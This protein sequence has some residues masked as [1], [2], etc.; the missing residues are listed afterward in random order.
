[1]DADRTAPTQVNIWWVVYVKLGQL[2][3]HSF[4]HLLFVY[5]E[6][7]FHFFQRMPGNKDRKEWPILY[8]RAKNGAVRQWQVRVERQEEGRVYIVKVYGQQDGKL[9][10]TRKEV[11][12]AKSQPTIWDQACRDAAKMHQDEIEKK[13]YSETVPTAQKR[14][15]GSEKASNNNKKVKQSV[16]FYPML[17]HKWPD[18]KHHMPF[19]CT[20]QPKLDGVRAWY[21]GGVFRSR[22]GKVFPQFKYLESALQECNLGR[23]I[24][25]D[26]ELY[27]HAI[28][29][30]TL[31][32]ICNRKGA[33]LTEVGDY[34]IG[35]YIFDAYFLAAPNRGFGARY[36]CLTKLLANAPEVVHIVG[37][38]TLQSESDVQLH[39]DFWT[40]KGYEGLMLRD[41]E[42]PYLVKHRSMKLLKYKVFHDAEFKIVGAQEGE[43]KEEG[44]LVWT[45]ETKDGEAFQC[46]PRGSH[47]ERQRLWQAFGKSP[48][49]YVGQTLTVR[50]QETYANGKPRFPVGI[51][52]RYQ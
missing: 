41:P 48:N 9:I 10:Q 4:R 20:G 26:G 52:I 18:K 12:R 38:V 21:Q 2:R 16:A 23:N 5:T 15:K 45:L 30:R 36:E 19:P 25:L 47:E 43:G 28:P 17:A 31:N 40:R 33:P 24:I 11:K 42:A 34:G 50:Y 44:C 35:Y 51:S 13:G 32:G 37:C 49:S 7:S 8:N 1:M 27:S 39:H 46:R 3:R 29:F 6:H 14:I 22:N